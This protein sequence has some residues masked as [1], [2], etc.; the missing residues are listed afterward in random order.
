MRLGQ[1]FSSLTG[2]GRVPGHPVESPGT[3]EHGSA[4]D[5][6]LEAEIVQLSLNSDGIWQAAAPAESST[7]YTQTSPRQQRYTRTLATV[8]MPVYLPTG[9]LQ[10]RTPTV[11]LTVDVYV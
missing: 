7:D 3:A 10:V 11:G 9:Q 5:T 6:T 4:R 8:G 2:S 1:V